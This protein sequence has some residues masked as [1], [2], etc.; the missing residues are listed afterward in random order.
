MSHAQCG[1]EKLCL[2]IRRSLGA[3]QREKQLSQK[4][5][6]H[7]RCSN[8]IVSVTASIFPDHMQHGQKPW[9]DYITLDSGL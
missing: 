6:K 4:R 3:V 8:N 1:K 7:K 5:S 2:D 9:G